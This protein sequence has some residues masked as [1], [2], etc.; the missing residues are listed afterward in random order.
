MLNDEERRLY[1]H[2]CGAGA[3][4]PRRR[5]VLSATEP[6]SAVT[7]ASATGATS[8][9]SLAALKVTRKYRQAAVRRREYRKLKAIVP[10]VSAKHAVS[11]LTIIEEAIK[12]IDT[13]HSTLMTRLHGNLD[14]D[15]LNQPAPGN[16]CSGCHANPD[17]FIR[18]LCFDS[19]HARHPASASFDDVISAGCGSGTGEM[20]AG[21]ERR[22]A[23][24]LQR[25]PLVDRQLG[26]PSNVSRDQLE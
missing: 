4:R 16:S 12:Y 1:L 17:A 23:N 11:K 13:L 24:Q 19:F 10:A 8:S 26:V 20:G 7:G 18:Q 9:R 25:L 14:A 2:Q 6:T 5:R 21:L 15:V 22:D 3:E